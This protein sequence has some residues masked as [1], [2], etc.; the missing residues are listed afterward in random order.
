[1]PPIS[2]LLVCTMDFINDDRQCF[3][4]L[5]LLALLFLSMLL[6]KTYMLN[7]LLIVT[8]NTELFLISSYA[9][10]VVSSV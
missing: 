7:H 3:E 6:L 4:F 10:S 8:S 2:E 9:V 5:V 1:M